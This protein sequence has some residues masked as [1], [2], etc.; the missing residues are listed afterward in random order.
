MGYLRHSGFA[1]NVW[2]KEGISPILTCVGGG[3]GRT[4][5]IIVEQYQTGGEPDEPDYVNKEES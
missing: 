4:P 2:D 5:S 3:G 1:G